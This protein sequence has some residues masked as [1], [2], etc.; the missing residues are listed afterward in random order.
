MQ[1]LEVSPAARGTRLMFV[2]TLSAKNI[3]ML[4]FSRH[5]GRALLTVLYLIISII[6]TSHQDYTLHSASSP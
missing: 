1:A 2:S 5:L 4:I 6:T 3:Y